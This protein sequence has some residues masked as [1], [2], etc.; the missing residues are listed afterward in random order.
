MTPFVK[1]VL[2]VVG[3]TYDVRSSVIVG[4]VFVGVNTS[5]MFVFSFRCFIYGLLP[6]T[7]NV[8]NV[9][10]SEFG[11]L[12]RVGYRIVAFIRSVLFYCFSYR[13]GF[14]V[15]DF[16]K[17]TGAKGWRFFVDLVEVHGVIR[18]FLIHCFG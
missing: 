9:G 15:Y 18:D 17:A 13:K 1:G 8:F 3:G 2:I 16:Q 6:W 11:Q 7:V 12:G 14:G 4:V 5:R 10:F